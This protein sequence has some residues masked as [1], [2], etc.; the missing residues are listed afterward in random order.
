M[1]GNQGFD[2]V[3]TMNTQ[4][5]AAGENG[6]GITR[7]AYKPSLMAPI[8]SFALTPAALIW[9]RGRH[10]GEIR[11]DQ[12]TRLRLSFRPATMQRGRYQLEIW[13]PVAPR[14]P[15]VSGT[16]RSLVEMQS[17]GAEFR[18]FVTEL[19]RRI[20]DAGGTP[21]CETGL[22]PPIY[23]I[24]VT[25]LA[26]TSL[27]IATMSV[28]ALQAGT[29]AGAAFILAFLALFLWQGGQFFRLN[30]PALYDVAYPPA[31]LLPAD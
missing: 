21:R 31:A 22:F 16:V 30:R 11:Y 29:W 23:W 5:D 4:P 12:I 3:L 28:R 14:M 27:A 6:D 7:Y 2:S 26:A 13:S 10:S 19:H 9:T 24:G 17:Q 18:A 1:T 15:I 25:V 8:F 20:A